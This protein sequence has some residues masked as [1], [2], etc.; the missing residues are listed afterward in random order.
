MPI[1]TVK[2]CTLCEEA[3]VITDV[4]IKLQNMCKSKYGYHVIFFQCY[5]T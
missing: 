2:G 5:C 1:L 4:D 3:G